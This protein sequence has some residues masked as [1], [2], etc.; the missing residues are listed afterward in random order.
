MTTKQTLAAATLCLGICT[1][2]ANAAPFYSTSTTGSMGN[3]EAW[4]D[5][6]GLTDGNTTNDSVILELFFDF[7]TA[8]DAK[9]RKQHTQSTTKKP[10]MNFFRLFPHPMRLGGHVAASNISL[11]PSLADKKRETANFRTK[12]I[13][14]RRK[15]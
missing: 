11:I 14:K 9:S 15:P 8:A 1:T 3:A 13:G 2:A 12:A 4:G 10:P 6:S 7:T 5:S